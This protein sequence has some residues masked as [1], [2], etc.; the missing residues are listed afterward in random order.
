MNCIAIYSM[1]PAILFP[2]IV[3]LYV[4][5]AFWYT[6]ENI[7]R[8]AQYFKELESWALATFTDENVCRWDH[9]SSS[10]YFY[11]RKQSDAIAF[12]LRLE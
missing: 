3:K 1:N 9:S 6:D 8:V 2:H 11:F 5:E 4:N 7:V 10:V 12:R